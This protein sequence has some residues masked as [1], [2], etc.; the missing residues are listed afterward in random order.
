[1]NG[2]QKIPRISGQKM[3]HSIPRV[4]FNPCSGGITTLCFKCT[5]GLTPV[6]PCLAQRVC[7]VST[8]KAGSQ[9]SAESKAAQLAGF[10]LEPGPATVARSALQATSCTTSI[11]KS[12]G[13]VHGALRDHPSICGA[14]GQP[15]RGRYGDFSFSSSVRLAK[16]LCQS[17]AVVSK[18]GRIASFCVCM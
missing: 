11:W 12:P 1:M 8:E 14:S 13:Q 18:V 10:C 3:A 4:S 16:L 9:Q 15:S 7:H 6:N 2:F 5:T 17:F